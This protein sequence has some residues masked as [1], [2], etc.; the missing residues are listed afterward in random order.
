[1][2]HEATIERFTFEHGTGPRMSYEEYDATYSGLEGVRAEWVDGEVI[3]F[4]PVKGI[5][6]EIVF[7][8]VRLLGGFVDLYRIGKIL[9]D[10]FEMRILD[11]RSARLPDLIFTSNAPLARY[12]DD[13]LLGPADL[14]VEVVSD[15]SVT[16]DRRHKL[17][18]YAAAGVP[19]YWIVDPRPGRQAFDAHALG[20]D[21]AYEP[22]GPDGRGRVHSRVLPGLWLDPAWLW[23]DPLPNPDRLLL[24]ISP[25]EVMG[26]ITAAY[27]ALKN[28]S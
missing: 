10:P 20:D 6:G 18:D 11:G 27:E 2:T 12:T 5:H 19:E 17:A 7:F 21:G 28:E 8:L 22:I 13:R 25:D 9:G 26:Q 24:R 1:M 16:R 15:D 4:V 3:E 23:Q 14:V